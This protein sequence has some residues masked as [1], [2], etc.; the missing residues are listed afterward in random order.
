MALPASSDSLR[1][2]IEKNAALTIFRERCNSAETLFVTDSWFSPRREQLLRLLS[3]PITDE[4]AQALRDAL[5]QVALLDA[6]IEWLSLTTKDWFGLR[7]LHW[8]R[9]PKRNREAALSEPFPWDQVE[10]C[11]RDTLLQ[12]QHE[13]TAEEL[14]G[15]RTSKIDRLRKKDGRP[16][17]ECGTWSDQLACFY[18]QSSAVTWTKK[19]GRA[20][21]LVVCDRCHVQ[22]QFFL[23]LMN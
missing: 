3:D 15:R 23:E 18:Y 11:R 9:Y 6:V 4:Q 1:G 14:V 7:P 17:P 12:E 21:W 19:C 13:P 8:D 22:V 2:G 16:C 10:V 5:Q 20:G